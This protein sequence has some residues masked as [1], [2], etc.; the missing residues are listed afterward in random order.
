MIQVNSIALR[1]VV[2]DV[3]VSTCARWRA[4]SKEQQLL[5]VRNYGRF[6]TSNLHLLKVDV[7]ACGLSPFPPCASSSATCGSPGGWFGS[8]ATT[9]PGFFLCR[10]WSVSCRCAAVCSEAE[11]GPNVSAWWWSPS[12]GWRFP[13][14]GPAT[15]GLNVWWQSWSSTT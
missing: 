8:S 3:F 5:V 10:G 1:R 11:A 12:S 6:P 9:R 4:Q 2:V 13:F 15:K 14:L 7:A